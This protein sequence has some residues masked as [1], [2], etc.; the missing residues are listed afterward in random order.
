MATEKKFA[1]F[2]IDGT[3]IRWQLYHALADALATKGLINKK[4][5]QAMRD[6]RLAWKKRSNIS[7]KDYEKRVIQAYEAVLVT[8]SF[9]EFDAAVEA[10]FT[11]YKDQI[12]TYTRD[13]IA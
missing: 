1:V 5:Y 2:D 11:E 8:L 13:L 7:F 9:S 3:L 10:V 4:D 6:A 12:Y